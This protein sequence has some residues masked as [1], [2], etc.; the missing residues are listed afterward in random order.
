MPIDRHRPIYHFTPDHWMND[1]IPFFGNGEYHLF[2]QHNPNGA[3][4]GTMHW[5]H[6]VSRDLVR[7]TELPIALAPTPGGPDQDGCFTGCVVE[8]GGQFCI[9]YTGIPRLEPLQQ[10]Q[11]LATSADLIS[12]EKHTRNP[13]IAAPPGGFGDC[14]RD[15]HAWREADGWWM[16]IGSELPARKGG[17]A[18]LYRSPDLIH[19]DYVHP[20]FV[21][22]AAE[23]G[24][25]FECPD[26]FPLGDQH[27]L[28]TSRGQTWWHAGRTADHRF[29]RERW[30]V[31][32]GGAL[33]AAKTL[34][35]DRGRRILWGWIRE[36][37]PGEAQKAAGW[38]G[39]L[40]LPRLLT[41]RPGTRL[42]VSSLGID[43]V[44]E[45]EALRGRHQR[46]ENLVLPADESG[47][48]LEEVEGD[49]L[50]LLIRFAPMNAPVVGVRVRC[51]PDGK[52]Y[53]EIAYDRDA[54]RLVDTPL[55]L[56][57]GEELVLRIYVDRSV[58]EAFAN[59]R[60]CQTLRFYPEREDCR[61]VRLFAQGGKAKI[62][63]VD[64][65]DIAP[66]RGE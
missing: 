29:T 58:I 19:W 60:A 42:R 8:E 56:G 9:L 59:G 34:R 52:E 24:H 65:W 49:A 6:T 27:V 37:R 66:N 31:V 53:A 36:E 17:A 39:V 10:V 57:D 28:L 30:G 12:W 15:P 16:V 45:L 50:E 62:R 20:L 5:G 21:G 14:F 3:F 26:F 25:D 23:T 41:L 32:D 63:S 13:V 48:L 38:S 11:C 33:Y 61:G 22:D 64:V 43:P 1:P 18:L 46:F 47:L 4:W 44:P 7:W 54:R 2:Y 40:S 35:D 51:S 55:E